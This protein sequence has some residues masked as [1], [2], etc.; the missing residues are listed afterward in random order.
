VTPRWRG[1]GQGLAPVRRARKGAQRWYLHHRPGR[2]RAPPA[3]R[4]GQGRRGG[5]SE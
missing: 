4:K 3:P 1:R 2:L 5:E